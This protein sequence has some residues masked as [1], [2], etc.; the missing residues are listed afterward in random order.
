MDRS[1]GRRQKSKREGYQAIGISGQEANDFLRSLRNFSVI[2]VMKLGARCLVF[3]LR[4]S[5]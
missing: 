3:A 1:K 5:V 2:C 4:S